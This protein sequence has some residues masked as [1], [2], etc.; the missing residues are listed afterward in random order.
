M[1]Q[2]NIVVSIKENSMDFPDSKQSFMEFLIRTITVTSLFDLSKKLPS[3][4]KNESISPPPPSILF[5]L[6]MVRCI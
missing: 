1:F 3:I 4:N 2:K 6:F 5:V